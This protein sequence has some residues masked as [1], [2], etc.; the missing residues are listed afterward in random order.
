[1]DQILLIDCG[2]AKLDCGNAKLKGF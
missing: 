2:N 1:L